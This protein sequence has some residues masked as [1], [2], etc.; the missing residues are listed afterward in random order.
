MLGYRA[1]RWFLRLFQ[2]RYQTVELLGH[3]AGPISDE[4]S[5][6]PVLRALNT[7]TYPQSTLVYIGRDEFTANDIPFQT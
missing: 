5:I 3:S 7:T 4:R 2:S 6:S 1:Y